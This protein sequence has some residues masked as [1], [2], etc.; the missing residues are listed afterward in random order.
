MGFETPNFDFSKSED[1][2]KFN[3]MSEKEQA[4]IKVD[5]H[6]DANMMRVIASEAPE[7]SEF[8]KPKTKE[9]FDNALETLEELK[10]MVENEPVAQKVLGQLA[11]LAVISGYTAWDVMRQVNAGSAFSKHRNDTFEET[12]EYNTEVSE[13]RDV[14]L[15]SIESV[16][17]KLKSLRNDA[18][19][20][21]NAEGLLKK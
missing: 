3:E 2:K 20:L 11:R 16:S 19:N 10:K 8:K 17:S 21:A 12:M 6:E 14:V 1:Q 5:A 13:K 7:Y 9:E 15:R 18:D 4:G